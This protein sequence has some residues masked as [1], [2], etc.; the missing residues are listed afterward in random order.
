MGYEPRR[1]D[2]TPVAQDDHRFLR[3]SESRRFE[4]KASAGGRLLKWRNRRRKDGPLPRPVSK[5]L[6]IRGDF[7]DF[8]ASA[9]PT[10]GQQMRHQLVQMRVH[11]PG[12]GRNIGVMRV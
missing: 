4:I 1:L 7:Q 2:R 10:D 6:I 8:R 5:G 12:R 11:R 9:Q 3:Y